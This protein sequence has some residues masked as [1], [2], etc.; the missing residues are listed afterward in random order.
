MFK[1]IGRLKY[2]F[3][4]IKLIVEVDSGI[5]DFY[6]ALI[7]RKINKQMH[8]AHIS[9]VRNEFPPKMENWNKYQMKEVEFDYDNYVFNDET[10]YWLNVQ[11]EELEDIRIELGL[12]LDSRLTRPPDGQK[13]FHITLGNIK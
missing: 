12:P 10:Y 8:A 7:P 5:V 4:P 1:S 9:V 11:C 2:F 6:R 3:D 13:F